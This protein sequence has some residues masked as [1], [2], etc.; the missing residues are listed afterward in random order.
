MPKRSAA[1]IV[2]STALV[3]RSGAN[4]VSNPSADLADGMTVVVA[5]TAEAASGKQMRVRRH[6][7]LLGDRDLP[8]VPTL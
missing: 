4:V 7:V 8:R 5:K 3:V 2:P 6:E 1:L